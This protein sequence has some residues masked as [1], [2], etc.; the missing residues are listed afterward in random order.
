[1]IGTW[2]SALSVSVDVSHRM[3]TDVGEQTLTLAA[4]ARSVALSAQ[5]MDVFV[6][7]RC[8][9]VWRARGLAR[10]VASATAG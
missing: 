6:L 2:V 7:L 1:M 9:P 5:I 4:V 3:K 10:A 8:V